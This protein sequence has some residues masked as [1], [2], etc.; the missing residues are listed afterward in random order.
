M[1][2]L[3]MMTKST[4]TKDSYNLLVFC[5]YNYNN[6]SLFLRTFNDGQ[7]EV[8]TTV[9]VMTAWLTSD[10]GG[11]EFYN[12]GFPTMYDGIIYTVLESLEI[13]L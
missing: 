3:S 10:E 1:D 11:A 8:I 12:R 13:G 6:H 7:T 2:F 4:V 5:H 9:V